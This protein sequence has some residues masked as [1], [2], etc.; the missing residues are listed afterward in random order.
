MLTLL[1]CGVVANAILPK[2]KGNGVG[3]N[4]LLINFGWGLAVFAGVYAAYTTAAHI[5]PAVTVGLW[6]SGNDFF[7]GNDELGLAPIEANAGNALVY[8]LAQII[9]A[10]LG[11]IV[12]YLAY[13][14][15]FDE[16]AP[17]A[18]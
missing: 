14:K 16:E 8:M 4:W 1:G 18:T 2:T 12:M 15:H 11:A 6:A 17:A 5:N 13:K 7:P 10:T 9:G 3:A